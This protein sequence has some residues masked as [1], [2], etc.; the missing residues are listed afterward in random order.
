MPI[1]IVRQVQ[2]LR[3]TSWLRRTFE[4]VEATFTVDVHPGLLD[5]IERHWHFARRLQRWKCL[6]SFRRLDHGH[7]DWRNK[8]DDSAS[9]SSVF[10]MLE[11]KSAVQGAMAI[12]RSIQNSHQTDRPIA[13][14]E[15]LETAPWNQTLL[16]GFSTYKAIGAGLAR[17]LRACHFAG[18]SLARH[19]LAIGGPGAHLAF[20][21]R[22]CFSR[23]CPF[24]LWQICFSRGW[25]EACRIEPWMRW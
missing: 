14:V 25:R 7:W 8:R 5:T 23:S 21:R 16:P 20:S 19:R 2:I 1:P 3:R 11:V 12:R 24:R 13:Y 6:V 9:D 22:R 4:Q 15:Y 18:D 10:L 17:S